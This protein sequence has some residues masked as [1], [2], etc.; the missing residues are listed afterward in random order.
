MSHLF[1]NFYILLIYDLQVIIISGYYA[2]NISS[3][4]IVTLK[5]TPKTTLRILTSTQMTFIATNLLQI[6]SNKIYTTT[7][8][9][10]T[11]LTSTSQLT[12]GKI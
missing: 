12:T 7:L 4:T 5:Q 3:L 8:T 6:T 11:T 10:K 9:T 2:T 1:F